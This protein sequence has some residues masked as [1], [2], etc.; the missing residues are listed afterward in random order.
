MVTLLLTVTVP[1]TPAVGSLRDDPWQFTKPV[2]SQGES[3]LNAIA[4]AT[5]TEAWAAGDERTAGGTH[6]SL[7]G[8]WDGV[9]LHRIPGAT[10]SDQ[11]ALDVRL[12]DL[13]IAGEAVWAVGRAT[14]A[15]DGAHRAR[16]E[17][18]SRTDPGAGAV[19]PVAAPD[20]HSEL[21]GIDM[22][23]AGLGWTV[24]TAGS[25]EDST[26]PLIMR[27]DGTS[28]AEQAGPGPGT[29]TNRLNA[30]AARSP[31][32]VWAVGSSTSWER[33]GMSQILV[34]NYDGQ[35]WAQVPAP[36]LGPH[37]NDLLGVTIVG[38]KEIMAVGY[39]GSPDEEP[40]HRQAVALLYDG[41]TWRVLP[42]ADP[43]TTEFTGVAAIY[44][45]EAWL[46]GYA[47]VDGVETA[48]IERFD[49]VTLRPSPIDPPI[50]PSATNN[51][52]ATFLSDIA[53]GPPNSPLWAVG[54]RDVDVTPGRLG[55]T[56]R[57]NT[58]RQS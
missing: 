40:G 52:P 14:P 56:L 29:R 28:W 44:G 4:V 32:D 55:S 9:A 21:G 37:F 13:D 42:A 2:A 51:F 48:H 38:D 20:L 36:D 7:I 43:R 3:A 8:R 26:R 31:W 49:G 5:P 1:V 25:A 22:V 16:I 50:A 10:D 19:F 46:A 17:R 39:T 54:W 41:A 23:H 57:R 34:L 45:V 11:P 47:M 58:V 12:A 15:G 35:S 24:G 27:W 30:V 6:Q 33:P 53:A 18:Y